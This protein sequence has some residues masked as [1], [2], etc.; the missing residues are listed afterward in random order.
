VARPNVWNS[1][2]ATLICRPHRFTSNTR[3]LSFTSRLCRSLF[4][5]RVVALAVDDVA[6]CY[7]RSSVVCLSV[8]LSVCH[9]REPCKSGQTDRNAVWDVDSGGPKESCFRCGFR[10]H[11]REWAILMAKRGRPRTC[12][13]MSGGRYTQSDSAGRGSG[14]PIWVY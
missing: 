9:D 10:S 5:G 13:G 2:P 1:L 7:R 11:M 6:C 3:D 12:P 14:M 4:L 8:C